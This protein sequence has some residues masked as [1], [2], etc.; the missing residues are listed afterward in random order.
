MNKRSL[1]FRGCAVLVLILIAACMMVVGRGHTVYLDNKTMEY[2]G[3]SYEA[4]YKVTVVVGGETVT[5]LYEKERGQ[6][7]NIGQTFRVTLRV[8]PEKNGTETSESFSIRLPYG[9]DGVVI[10]IPAYLAGLPE[11][12]Y[13]SEFVSLVPE[14]SEDEEAP[15][16]DGFEMEIGEDF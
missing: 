14:A 12:A 9:M 2:N 5:R 4:P 13:L 10:N 16:A 11:E 7:T 3:K 15:G 8:L 1:I 6:A